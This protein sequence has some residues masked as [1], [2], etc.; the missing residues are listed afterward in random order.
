MASK[1]TYMRMIRRIARI[2][3]RSHQSELLS[4]SKFRVK[5]WEEDARIV[6]MNRTLIIFVVII[7]I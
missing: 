6:L 1:N 4:I 3:M 2:Y 5:K 7:A